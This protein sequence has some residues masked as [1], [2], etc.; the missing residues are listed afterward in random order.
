M[1]KI[2]KC[3]Y[4]GRSFRRKYQTQ[5]Y[6][7]V[8]CRTFAYREQ[9]SKYKRKRKKLINDGILISDENEKL[10]TGFLSEHRHKSFDKEKEAIKKELERLGLA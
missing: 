8:N 10:G 2:I 7:C 4:C 6:C 1:K 9:R 5:K 3:K